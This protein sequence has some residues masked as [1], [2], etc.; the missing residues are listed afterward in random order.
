MPPVFGPA[1]AV[2]DPLVI[3][4][5]DRAARS[6][7]RRRRRRTRLRVRSG[8]PRGRPARP[9]RQTLGRPSRPE[10]PTSAV[11]RV[12][13]HDDALAG[14]QAVGLD[15][16]GLAQLS[17]SHDHR[18]ASSAEWQTRYR[19]VGT[20]WR[21]MKSLANALLVSSARRPR[22]RAE[23]RRPRSA[24]RSATPAA[25]G[26]SGADD[27]QVDAFDGSASGEHCVGIAQR[28]PGPS[29][30]SGRCP[31]L[32][33]AHNDMPDVGVEGEPPTERVFARAG[34]KNEDAHRGAASEAG[35]G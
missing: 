17:R 1:V 20:P 27:G 18:S 3:L 24:K 11:V 25:S 9:P 19:A 26:A 30:R 14:G 29:R 6:A 2:E 4:R 21:A 33:G 28:P 8:T 12:R 35:I 13:R 15:D 7:R 5:G 32:P 31:A 22:V 34:A 23:Q 16:D 10:W